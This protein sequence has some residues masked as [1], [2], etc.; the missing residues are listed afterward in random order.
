MEAC[1]GLGRP[2][3]PLAVIPNEPSEP[4]RISIAN[5]V[6]I[7]L[8]SREGAK[9]APATLRKHRT[10]TKQLCDFAAQRGYL[11]LAQLGIPAKPNAES[12]MIPNGI[13]G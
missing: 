1:R 5:A 9:I 3:P 11:M 7:F 8:T 2:P 10:F 13:P 6:R 4:Q 12:G